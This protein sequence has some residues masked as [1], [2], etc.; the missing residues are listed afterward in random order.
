MIMRETSKRITA[1]CGDL[2]ISLMISVRDAKKIL[3]NKKAA[4]N[5]E[6]VK[7]ILETLAIMAEQQILT[8]DYK[9]KKLE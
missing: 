1:A 7:E 8:E 2:Q 9:T 5:D 6:Q 3:N 4:Y